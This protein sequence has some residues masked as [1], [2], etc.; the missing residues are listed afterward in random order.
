MA[1]KYDYGSAPTYTKIA[2][3][4]YASAASSYTFSNIPQQYTD[5]ILVTNTRAQT[6]QASYD[7][8]IYLNLNGDMSS[9]LYHGTVMYGTGVNIASYRETGRNQVDNTKQTSTQS[10]GEFSPFIYN[11]MNYSNPNI[12]KHVIQRA[13]TSLNTESTYNGP[14]LGI[15]TWRNKAPITS[16]IVQAAGGASNGFAA[17][18][19]L[20]LYGIKAAL[21]P[22]ATGGDLIRTDGT[23]WYHVFNNSGVFSP[24]QTISTDILTVAG[25]GSGGSRAGGGG[26]AGGLVYTA[27]QSLTNS[28]GYTVTVGAGGGRVVSMPS[29]RGNN[30]SNT[31]VTGGSLS[32]TTAVG[33]GGGGVYPGTTG[34]TATTGGSGGG[35]GSILGSTSGAGAAGTAGQGNSGGNGASNAYHGGGGGGAGGGG[36]GSNGDAG[37]GGPGGVGLSTYS[38]WSVGQNVSGTYYLAGGGGGASSGIGGYG[39]GGNSSTTSTG[40]ASHGL[41]NTGGGGGGARNATDTYAVESGSGGSGI[42]VMRYAV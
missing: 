7:I 22:K 40:N 34:L 10:S 39:G 4:T 37:T 1:V 19:T 30:G 42:V 35:G 32:L 5:L 11:I 3:T 20:T 15:T 33:G 9:G 41:A 18:S 26:G 2:S 12:F 28:F 13:N 27:S 31:T 38:S 36:S 24:R 6:G 21:V 14:G 25:G 23:Y 16:I 29:T 17:G 8:R